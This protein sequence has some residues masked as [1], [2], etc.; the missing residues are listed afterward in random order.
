METSAAPEECGR[1]SPDI[2]E[3]GIPPTSRAAVRR[4]P[5]KLGTRLGLFVH[6]E[7]S[8]GGSPRWLHLRPDRQD[9]LHP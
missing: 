7:D 5:G 4:H 8:A 1:L 9:Y 2:R 3:P 6:G